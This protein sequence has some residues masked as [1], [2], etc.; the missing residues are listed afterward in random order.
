M[1][2]GAG[3]HWGG[4]QRVLEAARLGHSSKEQG[5]KGRKESERNERRGV[6][7][8][9]RD[10]PCLLS[11]SQ[12]LS[13]QKHLAATLLLW[14]QMKLRSEIPIEYEPEG[15]G[16]PACRSE[17]RRPAAQRHPK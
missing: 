8:S 1:A 10:P 11:T 9:W 15:M 3:G 5:A 4:P 17:G 12:G 2:K 13:Q 16:H 14:G 7:G 6:K